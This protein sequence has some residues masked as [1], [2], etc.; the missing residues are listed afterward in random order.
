MSSSIISISWPVPQTFH[1]E[2]QHTYHKAIDATNTKKNKQKNKHN[3]SAAGHQAMSSQHFCD[4]ALP[5]RPHHGPEWWAV[6]PVVFRW[7]CSDV[8]GHGLGLCTKS[9]TIWQQVFRQDIW[10]SVTFCVNI[11]CLQYWQLGSGWYP[12]CLD[13]ETILLKYCDNIL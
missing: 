4:F 11:F 9:S 7:S 1:S 8:N 13:I 3:L 2:V 5:G 6:Q 10:V 12:R